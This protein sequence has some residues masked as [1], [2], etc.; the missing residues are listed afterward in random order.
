ML[1]RPL[2][3]AI[4]TVALVLLVLSLLRVRVSICLKKQLTYRVTLLG[5]PILQ[6]PR[7]VW[8]RVLSPRI[9]RAYER[10]C[11]RKIEKKLAKKAA[12]R[13]VRMGEGKTLADKTYPYLEEF[14]LIRAQLAV[15]LRKTGKHVKLRIARLHARLATGDA[16]STA[17]L[18]GATMSV[19]CPLLSY[20]SRITRL[21]A[22]QVDVDIA[23]DFLGERSRT[24]VRLVL[25]ISLL[26]L[27]P[28][29]IALTLS[30]LGAVKPRELFAILK[31]RLTRKGK[32][33]QDTPCDQ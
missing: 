25:S 23:P 8:W 17:V 28:L 15:L 11:D 9:A 13:I 10:Y 18:Y 2:I 16:A 7:R 20:L 27:I 33:S 3:T 31:Y 4:G 14:R 12:R 32:K 24:D 5:V 6:Y 22:R 30:Y 19:L 29:L 1:P 26:R 21:T